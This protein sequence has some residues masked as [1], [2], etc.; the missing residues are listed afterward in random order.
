M[1][2][3][4]TPV[5]NSLLWIFADATVPTEWKSKQARR[6]YEA[7]VEAEKAGEWTTHA[8]SGSVKAAVDPPADSPASPYGT[9]PEH[10]T[11]RARRHIAKLRAEADRLE[12]VLAAYGGE[13]FVEGR[14]QCR[15]PRHP[16]DAEAMI[17][18]LISRPRLRALWVHGVKFV[19]DTSGAFVRAEKQ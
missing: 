7:A 2:R 16:F 11:S 1:S 12:Q 4:I 5:A 10:A 19:R 9:D 13:A 8:V 15:A 14:E 17:T 18:S 6:I 3:S